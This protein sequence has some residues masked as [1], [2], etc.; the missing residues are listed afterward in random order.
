[1][2]CSIDAA[3]GGANAN[4]YSTVA[5]SD[6]YHETHLYSADWTGATADQKCRALVSATR[7]L[8]LYI[9]WKGDPA[10]EVQ[11]L[12]WPRTGLLD[13]NGNE[14]AGTELPQ[15]LRDITAELARKLI[16]SDLTAGSQAETE[17][18]AGLKAGEI[19][20]EWDH[21]RAKPIPDSVFFMIP[22]SW[23]SLRSRGRTS[24]PLV[25]T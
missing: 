11:A 5:E 20:L 17:G 22:N 15:L 2:A 3:V 1:M 25:R 4:S 19:E 8:D 7:M 16:I 6:A 14:I 10:D 23:G 12:A 18:L 9:Q 13:T 21:P 24:V